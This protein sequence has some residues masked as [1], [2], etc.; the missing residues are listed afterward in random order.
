MLKHL[1]LTKMISKTKMKERAGKKGNPEM[2]KL[3][4]AL[5]KGNAFWIQVAYHLT[6]PRRQGVSVNIGKLNGMTKEND[7]VIIPGKLLSG[8]EL[9][10]KVTVSAFSCS[11]KAK[12]KMKG[13]K[14][15]S[16]E[17]MFKANKDGKGVKL[18]A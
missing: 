18:I 12:E 10:H 3:V 8:G 7:I 11:E 9:D 17:D 6:R 13:S 4:D 1:K 2:K 15:V 5:K 16:I 14:L